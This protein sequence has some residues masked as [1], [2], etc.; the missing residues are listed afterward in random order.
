MGFF[1]TIEGGEGA[2]KTTAMGVI[3]AWLASRDIAFI[4]TREPGGTPMAEAVRETLLA[5]YDETVN[6]TTEL[7]LMF[8]A[9]SQN[10]HQNIELAMAEGK[11]VVCD[12]FTDATYAYQW[13]GRGVDRG[14]IAT[15]ETLVQGER[16]PDLTLLLD[17]D[18]E[19]GLTRA[20]GRGK[21]LDRIEQEDIAF[22][23]RVRAEYLD[24]AARY[25]RQYVVIDADR[26]LAQVKQ[27]IEAVLTQRLGAC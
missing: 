13:G 25:P 15:L 19:A 1:L 22:F 24:R 21:A 2:G 3:T 4:Q 26:S 12:R 18:P 20:W 11:V 8:A 6:S 27:H 5:S 10:L 9:R 23:N 17:I 14:H 7:L 16:R